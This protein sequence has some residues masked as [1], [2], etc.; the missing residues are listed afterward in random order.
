VKA[1]SGPRG[2][3][4][5]AAAQEREDAVVARLATLAPHLDGEPDPEWQATARARLV[6]MAAVRTPEP[7]PVSRLRRLLGPRDGQRSPWRTR[8]TAGMA[9]AAAA[10]TALAIVVALSADARPG[11]ALYGVKRG[12]EQTALALAGDARGMT[13]LG[14]ASTRLSELDAILD[15]E[16]DA[17][18]LRGT[19]ETMDEQS[20][21]GAAWLAERAVE[22]RDDGPLDDLAGWA[23][24]QSAGLD[25]LLPAMPAAVQARADDS[26]DLL[27]RIDER[28]DALRVALACPAG[29][30][31][32]GADRLGP[33]PGTCDPES[34]S[35]PAGQE[36]GTTVTD[37]PG[38]PGTPGT[39]PGPGG[40]AP[41][42]G[43]PGGPTDGSSPDSGSGGS[44]EPGLPTDGLP[45]PSLPLPLPD[46]TPTLPSPL[47]SLP[48][49]PS[50]PVDDLVPGAEATDPASP[51]RGSDGLLPCVPL[52]PL[53]E[54]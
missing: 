37:T 13:L 38:A 46:G 34:P 9:G 39:S 20:A 42:P 6:A 23:A 30:A 10:V 40:T 7:A 33:V 47:P 2:S 12:T 49:L 5:R 16:D 3:T 26:A 21:D 53:V 8:L 14:F 15:A 54:C 32:V 22:G 18:L 17:D 48:A 25:A 1:H 41:A 35:S 24:G 29:P 4:S 50:L 28:V 43:A 11:D 44:E 52:P 31:T 19:L 51:S 27:T 36:P 45:D